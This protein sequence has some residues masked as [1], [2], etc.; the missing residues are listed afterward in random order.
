MWEYLASNGG[1]LVRR[2]LCRKLGLSTIGLALN[3][4]L[5]NSVGS[6]GLLIHVIDKLVYFQ[7]TSLVELGNEDTFF[8]EGNLRKEVDVA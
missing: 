4:F 7:L 6:P 5:H 1:T 2:G 8:E 3:R